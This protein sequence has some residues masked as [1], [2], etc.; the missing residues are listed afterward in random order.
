MNDQSNDQDDNL[1]SSSQTISPHSLSFPDS[2]G[3]RIPVPEEI[4]NAG[5]PTDLPR[6]V[7]SPETLD[8]DLSKES[9]IED[10]DKLHVPAYKGEDADEEGA[11]ID[12]NDRDYEDND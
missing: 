9:D 7:D 1:T 11:D 4:I 6:D 12:D 5:R 10:M 3:K 2:I 8:E